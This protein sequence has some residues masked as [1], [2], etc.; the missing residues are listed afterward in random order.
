MPMPQASVSESE[1]EVPTASSKSA[2]LM[3]VRSQPIVKESR[4]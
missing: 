3:P 4:G 2:A 1:L